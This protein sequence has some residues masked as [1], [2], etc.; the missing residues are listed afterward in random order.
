[1][2]SMPKNQRF[3]RT[4]IREWRKHREMTLEKL[5][6]HA[7]LTA[8]YLSMLERGQRGYTQDTL[9]KIARALKTDPGNLLAIEPA[10]HNELWELW[11]RAKPEQRQQIVE[12]T[13]VFLKTG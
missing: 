13:K 11:N 3:S 9:E 5:A 4:F 6:E 2:A 12:I 1:M 10:E 7:G 8:S